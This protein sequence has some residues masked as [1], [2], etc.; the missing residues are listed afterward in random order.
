MVNE[1]KQARQHRTV[2]VIILWE[3]VAGELV[4]VFV[5]VYSIDPASTDL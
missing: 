2:V 3:N 1:K 4:R 5:D